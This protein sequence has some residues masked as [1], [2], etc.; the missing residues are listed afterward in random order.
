MS[1]ARL[2]IGGRGLDR[3]DDYVLYVYGSYSIVRKA[4]FVLRSIVTL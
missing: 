1:P 3:L 2:A 4:P